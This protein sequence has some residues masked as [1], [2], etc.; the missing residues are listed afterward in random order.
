MFLLIKRQHTSFRSFSHF[1][2][3][4]CFA[5]DQRA[6]EDRQWV[7]VRAG[8]PVHY[9]VFPTG[10]INRDREEEWGGG[11][12]WWCGWGG[13]ENQTGSNWGNRFET[14]QATLRLED[15]DVRSVSLHRPPS[16]GVMNRQRDMQPSNNSSIQ[17]QN[18]PFIH[19]NIHL[20]IY[21]SVQTYSNKITKRKARN[22]IIWNKTNTTKKWKIFIYLFNNSN[23]VRRILIP[24]AMSP[25]IQPSLYV[26]P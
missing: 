23:T 15:G 18:Q 8:N 2:D 12:C 19:S 5:G 6:A 24:Q 20:F 25:T 9:N 1:S 10:S 22:I 11:W 7:R 14:L 3:I 16:H 17:P 13:R 4:F 26:Q 21:A